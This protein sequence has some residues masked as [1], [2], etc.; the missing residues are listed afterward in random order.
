MRTITLC[1]DSKNRRAAL[2]RSAKRLCSDSVP[3]RYSV[4]RGRG[5]GLALDGGAW[6]ASFNSE[7]EALHW[8]ARQVQRGASTTAHIEID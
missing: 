1:H 5:V 8:S 2:V 6:E 7:T 3:C 4:E